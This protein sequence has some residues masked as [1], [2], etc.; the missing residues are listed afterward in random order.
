MKVVFTHTDFRIYWPARLKSL[1]GYLAER[2]IDLE[3]IEIAGAGSNYSFDKQGGKKESNWHC[4]FPDQKIEDLSSFIANREL[5]KKLDEIS[6]EI[7]FAGSI[8]FPSGS[9]AV[10]WAGENSRKCII[11]DDAR[12]L[13]VSRNW[14]VDCIK[15]KVYS[16]VEAVFCPAPDWI[17]TFSHFGFTKGQLFYGVDVVDNQFWRKNESAYNDGGYNFRYFLVVGRL[18]SKKN[19]RFLLEAYYEYLEKA[20]N[21]VRLV[22]VGDGP[23]FG[24]L[25]SYVIEK[26]I[27]NMIDFYPFLSQERLKGLYQNASW[28]ILPSRYGETWGLV[29]NEAMASGLPILVSDMAGCASTLVR[30][31]ENGYTFSPDDAEELSNL[32]INV[33][34]MPEG[35]R[36]RMGCRSEEII[37]EWDLD[38]FCKGAY[39]AIKYVSVTPKKQ[40]DTL[41]RVITKFWNGRY[42]PL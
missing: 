16:C 15:R 8:A 6:P 11:F 24:Y 5:R 32:L 13:D 36:I 10:R 25:K 14:V 26:G 4:L 40:P 42:R 41:S 1:T 30:I 38:R 2:D 17:S 23:E 33:S 31:G 3:I 29:V 12:N 7:V 22:L 19:Y 20:V 28:F 27:G 39:E 18:I 34:L 37:S 9:A 21:P 35:E